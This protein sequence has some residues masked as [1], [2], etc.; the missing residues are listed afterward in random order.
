MGAPQH[1]I[2]EVPDGFKVSVNL[3]LFRT[4][5]SFVQEGRSLR[6]H[7]GRQVVFAHKLGLDPACP[8]SDQQRIRMERDALG[9]VRGQE[10]VHLSGDDADARE[11]PP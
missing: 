4:P 5:D 2:I 7:P 8:Q 3:H 6:A 9:P 1:H 11:N 10:V